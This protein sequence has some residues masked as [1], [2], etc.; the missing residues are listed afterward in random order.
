MWRSVSK[1]AHWVHG[2]IRHL[3]TKRDQL[4][5]CHRVHGGIRHLEILKL[6]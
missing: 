1:V 6:I 4:T 2:G 3:E 5:S